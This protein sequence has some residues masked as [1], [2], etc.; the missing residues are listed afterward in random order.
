MT[1]A[2]AVK[3]EDVYDAAKAILSQKSGE[4]VGLRLEGVKQKLAE[5]IEAAKSLVRLSVQPEVIFFFPLS[6]FF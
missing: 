3:Y 4:K 1:N 5:K 6:Q 2:V